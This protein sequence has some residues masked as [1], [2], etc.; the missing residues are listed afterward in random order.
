[1][2]HLLC[3]GDVMAAHLGKTCSLVYMPGAVYCSNTFLQTALNGQTRPCSRLVLA[4][5]RV[6]WHTLSSP[7]SHKQITNR[8][9]NK[10]PTSVRAI[11][12]CS[13]ITKLQIRSASAGNKPI[14]L[15]KMGINV[16]TFRLNKWSEDVRKQQRKKSPLRL[17]ITALYFI[18]LH[19]HKVFIEDGLCWWM[20]LLF[21]SVK[22]LT[23]SERLQERS[24]TN[25]TLAQRE[26]AGVF[27]P[28]DSLKGHGGIKHDDLIV[29][30]A[31]S[32]DDRCSLRTPLFV[33]ISE[34][35]RIQATVTVGLHLAACQEML[36][37]WKNVWT[38]PGLWFKGCPGFHP[39]WHYTIYTI[40]W[41]TWAHLFLL[42]DL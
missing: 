4:R 14:F 33:F 9:S 1:M 31:L 18:L 25:L 16:N 20:K 30:A 11:V 22:Q 37:S 42:W 21:R 40:C 32:L 29:W 5:E 28:S 27:D 38:L 15:S 12:L 17:Q 41:Q 13:S 7:S 2:S 26:P 6:Q 34:L 3:N 39:N 23:A 35:K 19:A 10:C 24:A 8:F 36:Q